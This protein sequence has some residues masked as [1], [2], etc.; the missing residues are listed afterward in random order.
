L[1]AAKPVDPLLRSRAAA[2]LPQIAKVKEN[3]AQRVAL[4]PFQAQEP[5][6]AERLLA[7]TNESPA[8][9]ARQQTPAQ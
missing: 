2:E 7:L 1:A 6:G 5:I 8:I 3:L 9:R 4:V